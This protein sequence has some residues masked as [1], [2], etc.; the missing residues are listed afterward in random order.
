MLH[1]HDLTVRVPGGPLVDGVSFAVAPGERVGVVGASGAG[2]SQLV[3]ALLGLTPP[4]PTV[5]GSV[6]VEGTEVVGA[7]AAAWRPLRGRVTALVA[8]DPGTALDPLT[9]VGRQ[10]A[11]PLR[12]QGVARGEA[13]TRAWALLAEVGLDG[14]ARRYPA[15]LSGGQRQRV[16][17]ALALVGAPRLL[18]ADEPTSALDVTVQAGVLDLL[19]RVTGPGLAALLLVTHDLAVATR[20]CSRLLVLEGGRLVADGPVADV[21]ADPRLADVVAASRALAVHR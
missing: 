3:A 4:G 13:H 10:V 16:A 19:D 21:L 12:A 14:L 17:L 18:V 20:L 8:Q 6:R 11:L 1:V 2:K 5:S 9:R 15:Q 7:S